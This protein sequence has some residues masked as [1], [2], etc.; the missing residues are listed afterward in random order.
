M[1]I[2]PKLTDEKKRG[3]KWG[4]LWFFPVYP[5]AQLSCLR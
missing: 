3:N 5:V 2:Y 4:H 1:T